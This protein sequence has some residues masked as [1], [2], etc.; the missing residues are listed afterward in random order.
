MVLTNRSAWGFKFGDR[1]GSFIDFT[2]LAAS[3]P[4]D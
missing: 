1:G 4:R 3:V 2:P